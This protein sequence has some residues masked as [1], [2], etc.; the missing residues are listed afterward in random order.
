MKRIFA[1]QVLVL[2]ALLVIPLIYSLSYNRTA[3]AVY[4]NVKVHVEHKGLMVK[5]LIDIDGKPTDFIRALS[6]RI[7]KDKFIYLIIARHSI[8]N[9]VIQPYFKVS[10]NENW[11]LGFYNS[12]VY[13]SYKHDSALVVVDD[14]TV[15]FD[16]EQ[17]RLEIDQLF[18]HID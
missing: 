7:Y 6:F 13:V 16:A 11:P 4:E 5:W 2:L 17:S 18:N 15:R 1:L 12:L 14:K 9:S 3:I 10:L 8:E